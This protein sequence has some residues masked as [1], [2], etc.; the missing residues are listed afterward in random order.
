MTF[1]SHKPFYETTSTPCKVSIPYNVRMLQLLKQRDLSNSSAGNSLFLT[2]Q[3][4]LLHGH[5]LPCGLVLAF[6]HH[7]IGTCKYNKLVI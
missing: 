6:I 4:D 7:P 1:N 3:T 2:L 5:N